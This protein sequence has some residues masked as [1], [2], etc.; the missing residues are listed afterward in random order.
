VTTTELQRTII[1]YLTQTNLQPG[2]TLDTLRL[3]KTGAVYLKMEHADWRTLDDFC[4]QRRNISRV[5]DIGEHGAIVYYPG[6]VA[7][8][9]VVEE[10]ESL[11]PV[12]QVLEPVEMELENG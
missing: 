11:Q 12:A 6:R 1:S 2:F 5:T 4:R 7:F 10:W 8:E 9:D 3:E